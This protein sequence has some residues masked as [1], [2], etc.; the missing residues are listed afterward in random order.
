MDKFVESQEKLCGLAVNGRESSC[1]DPSCETR[2]CGMHF[3]P[4]HPNK[5]VRVVRPTDPPSRF[6]G[7]FGSTLLFPLCRQRLLL[8]RFPRSLFMLVFSDSS[9]TAMSALAVVVDTDYICN[10]ALS[11]NE[12]FALG[13]VLFTLTVPFSISNFNPNIKRSSGLQSIFHVRFCHSPFSLLADARTL[14]FSRRSL[15]SRQRTQQPRPARAYPIKHEVLPPQHGWHTAD[16]RRG[17]SE[18]GGGAYLLRLVLLNLLEPP[19]RLLLLLF[20][21]KR[22]LQSPLSRRSSNLPGLLFFL[23]IDA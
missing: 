13:I 10:E 14:L 3:P 21:K 15:L 6:F 17:N 4:T 22:C 1:I 20:R 19:D 16:A 11:A 18:W 9:L 23:T 5:Q 12:Q 2:F 7:C 8:R